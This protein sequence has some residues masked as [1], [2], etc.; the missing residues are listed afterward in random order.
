MSYFG[1]EL[2]KLQKDPGQRR[3]LYIPY[4]QL[5]DRIGPLSR[6]EPAS[7]G[8]ILIENRLKASRR[9]Y[10]K[11]KLALIVANMRHFALEQADRGVAVAYLNIDAP[12]RSA[13]QPVAE[14]SGTIRVMEPAEYEL[15]RDLAPLVDK[16]LIEIIPHEGWLT[17]KEQFLASQ[18][19]H[20]PWRMD[21]FYRHIRQETGILMD[22]GRPFGGKYSHDADNRQPWSGEPP[23]AEPPDFPVDPIKKEVGDLI[24]GSFDHHPGT[25]DL[26]KLPATEVDAK[27][28][29]DW[30]SRQCLQNFGP[31]ED[32]MSVKSTTLFHSR[33]SSL[34]NIHRLQP[35]D[36]LADVLKMDLPLASKEGF[37]RQVIGWRDLCTTSIILRMA[38]AAFP[39]N[40]FRFKKNRVMRV[41]DHGTIKHGR[42]GSSRKIST[43]VSI[44]GDSAVFTPL[45]VAFWGKNSGLYCLDHVVKSVWQ[46]AYSHHITRLMILAN[47]ATLLEVSPRDLR[48]FFRHRRQDTDG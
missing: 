42:P 36:V 10:H 45:P 44:P 7:L 5:S 21:K 25:L 3:W 6:E 22:G 8:I 12:Y 33:I 35:A 37:V 14:K 46:E 48:K 18:K 29:W 39:E 11:Q 20:P 38:S 30:A 2:K 1:N 17:S 24:N 16:G 41:T 32:A 34:L 9:P 23:A 40:R 26:D 31:Y 47:I 27:S 43:E 28:L 13:L 4:D 15:R 19:P